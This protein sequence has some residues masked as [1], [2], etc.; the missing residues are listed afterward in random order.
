MAKQAEVGKK[1]ELNFGVLEDTRV[2][3]KTPF[4]VVTP[5]NGDEYPVAGLL[6]VKVAFREITKDGANYKKGDKIAI[7][8][9]HFEDPTYKHIHFEDFWRP[10]ATVGDKPKTLQENLDVLK[11]QL[12][13]IYEGYMGEK[14]AVGIGAEAKNFDQF[15]ELWAKAFNEG[16]KDKPVFKTIEDKPILVYMKLTSYKGNLG[17][18]LYP[19]FFQ[20]VI[21]KEGKREK[22]NFSWNPKY[23]KVPADEKPDSPNFAVP[24]S[25]A[26]KRDIKA[27]FPDFV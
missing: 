11:V 26:G 27:E 12:A 16:N 8:Q 2:T 25:V 13:H 20:K 6:D 24:G 17:F 19:N 10:T 4:P 18:P 15:F 21:T 3:N 5:I 7:L 14:S 9:F 23:D 22:P 1:D